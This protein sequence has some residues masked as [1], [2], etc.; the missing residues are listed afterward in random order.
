MAKARFSAIFFIRTIVVLCALLLL[1]LG[2]MLPGWQSLLPLEFSGR[3]RIVQFSLVLLAVFLLTGQMLLFF[4]KTKNT[5]AYI[6]ATL[7]S[8]V[9]AWAAAGFYYSTQVPA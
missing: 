7:A 6:W 4:L 3:S 9:L 2:W 8:L 5:A 1:L